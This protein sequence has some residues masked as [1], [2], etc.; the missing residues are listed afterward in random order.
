MPELGNDVF[1]Q[2]SHAEGQSLF[3]SRVVG[4]EGDHFLAE[5][6]EH[7]FVPDPGQEVM[8]F[9]NI[10]NRFVKQSA[11]IEE[12]TER[13]PVDDGD[14]PVE[15]G[16]SKIAVRVETYGQPMSAEGRSS[17]R[18]STIVAR[19]TVGFGSNDKCPLVDVSITG[20][21]LISAEERDIGDVVN[22]TLYFEDAEQ[23]GLV[24]VQS[25]RVLRDCCFRYGVH[26]I[27]SDLQ[28]MAQAI[29]MEQQRQQ[30]RRMAG[31]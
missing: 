14:Q 23:S 25:K 21:G 10:R 16:E 20:F 29:S 30:L 1:L 26:C 2:D 9:Y 27:G 8:V 28:V 11:R 22:A 13:Q 12:V 19:L 7:D 4:V 6:K 18:V 3:S 31:V 5:L 15:D 24:R 17:F